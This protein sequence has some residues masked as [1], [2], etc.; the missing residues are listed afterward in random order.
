MKPEKIRNP[1]NRAKLQVKLESELAEGAKTTRAK[2]DVCVIA[3]LI[4]ATTEYTIEEAMSYD[5]IREII[6]EGANAL[7]SHAIDGKAFSE[8]VKRARALRKAH[9]I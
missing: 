7:T 3:A 8:W 6:A 4:V 5:H 9:G 1:T 2:K